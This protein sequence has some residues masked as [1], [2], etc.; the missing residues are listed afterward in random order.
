MIVDTRR[1]VF[2]PEAVREA[3]KLYRASFPEKQPPGSIGPIF[4][5]NTA[6]VTLGVSVQA[7]GATKHREIEMA[8]SEVAVMLILYCR[9]AKIPLPRTGAKAIETQGDSLV[10][11]VSKA[12]Q[13]VAV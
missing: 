9:K 12:M 6:P 10:L 11:S 8:A 7:V 13:T 4:I 3:V 2:S 1:I 5:R